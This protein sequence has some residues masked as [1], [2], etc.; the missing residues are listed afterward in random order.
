MKPSSQSQAPPAPTADA[1]AAG[2]ASGGGF[3][4]GGEE[5]AP[6]TAGP[7]ARSIPAWGNAPCHRRKQTM[8]ANG[9]AHPFV[10]VWRVA[11]NGA[12][13]CDGP[14]FQPLGCLR[15]DTWG[16][17]PGWFEVAPLAL[18]EAS[19]TCL[20]SRRGSSRSRVR[21]RFWIW[22]LSLIICSDIGSRISRAFA[23][24]FAGGQ[25]ILIVLIC[26]SPRCATVVPTMDLFQV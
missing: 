25:A 14:G 6:P 5:Y 3:G 11:M 12:W 23:R 22:R 20:D 16:V 10:V 15:F 8:S 18:T 2:R 9:A 21:R 1:A 7:K 19:A 17:A 4:V 24:I 26:M 13:Q